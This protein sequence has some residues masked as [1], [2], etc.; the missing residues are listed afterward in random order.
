M[1]RKSY[2]RNYYLL[3]VLNKCIIESAASV[4]RPTYVRYLFTE[5]VAAALGLRQG[6]RQ[7]AT[8]VGGKMK[9]GNW[10]ENRIRRRQQAA[11]RWKSNALGGR[12]VTE[13]PASAVNLSPA[14]GG[15]PGEGYRIFAR[16]VR[17]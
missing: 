6:A 15:R 10:S 11:A 4:D 14:A 9:T 3:S 17:R 1:A 5:M 16:L 8:S 12:V 2:S 13:A 7:A